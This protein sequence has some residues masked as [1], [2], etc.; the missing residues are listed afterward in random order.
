MSTVSHTAYSETQTISAAS[1]NTIQSSL[2]SASGSVNDS[3]IRKE[4]L[5]TRSVSHAV[6]PVFYWATCQ[7]HSNTELSTASVQTIN[8]TTATYVQ[9]VHG[10]KNCIISPN[11]SVLKGMIVRINFHWE[12]MNV[13]YSATVPDRQARF[14]VRTI[15]SSGGGTTID[16]PYAY[17][18]CHIGSFKKYDVSSTAAQG[19]RRQ[20]SWDG[21]FTVPATDTLE[22]VALVFENYNGASGGDFDTKLGDGAMTVQVYNR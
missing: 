18:R 21:I 20:A 9:S 15:W 16:N 10:S 14:I 2:E 7:S 17:G 13:T 11:I 12:V 8:G 1:L 6:L 22:T 3:N 4:S 19:Q 5:D